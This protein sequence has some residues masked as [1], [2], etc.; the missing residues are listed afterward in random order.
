MW[1][2]PLFFQWLASSGRICERPGGPGRIIT[3]RPARATTGAVDDMQQAQRVECSSC[4]AY[5]WLTFKTKTSAAARRRSFQI[6][7][8][9]GR[10]MAAEAAPAPGCA[11]APRDPDRAA[12]PAHGGGITR[13]AA[14]SGPAPVHKKSVLLVAGRRGPRAARPTQGRGGAPA[15]GNVPAGT[16]S[17]KHIFCAPVCGAGWAAV[18]GLS[19]PRRCGS[20]SARQLLRCSFWGGTTTPPLGCDM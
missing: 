12:Q 13:G 7:A 11:A 20:G 4:H 14:Q 3:S 18:G 8:A 6:P 1:A 10:T 17:T 5:Q 2:I 15:V 19:R 16:R 9:R